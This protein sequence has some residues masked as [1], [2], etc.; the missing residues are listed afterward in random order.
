MEG[1]GV[2]CLRR[3]TAPNDKAVFSRQWSG[4]QTQRRHAALVVDRTALLAGGAFHRGTERST[5]GSDETPT[6]VR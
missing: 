6:S 4:S 3:L 2:D 5:R 1:G